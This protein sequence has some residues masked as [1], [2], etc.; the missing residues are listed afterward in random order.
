M[1]VVLVLVGAAQELDPPVVVVKDDEA[2]YPEQLALTCHVYAVLATKP[3]IAFEV[4]VV[5]A[6][7]HVLEV[8]ILYC[9][10]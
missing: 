8:E 1:F 7:L 6:V 4:D 5:V 3:V 10:V 2:E 9:T